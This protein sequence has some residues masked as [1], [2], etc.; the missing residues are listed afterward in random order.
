[1]R[2]GPVGRVAAVGAVVV[3]VRVRYVLGRV[4]VVVVVVGGRVLLHVAVLGVVP[5]QRGLGRAL[6]GPLVVDGHRVLRVRGRLG[7]GG[8]RGGLRRGLPS[9]APK[10]GAQEGG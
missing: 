3:L 4:V 5:V 8:G 1:M 9:L 2:V 6:G 7:G 10:Q